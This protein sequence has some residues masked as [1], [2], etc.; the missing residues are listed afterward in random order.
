M[1]DEIDDF[2]EREKK[3]IGYDRIITINRMLVENKA[4]AVEEFHNKAK[5]E[6]RLRIYESENGKIRHTEII[7][8]V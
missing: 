5:R 1:F 7:N 6:R 4:I 2:L 8:T 3:L